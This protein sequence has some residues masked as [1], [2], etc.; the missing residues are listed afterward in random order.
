MRSGEEKG[1]G[2]VIQGGGILEGKGL[3]SVERGK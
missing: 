3:K 1:G 2:E